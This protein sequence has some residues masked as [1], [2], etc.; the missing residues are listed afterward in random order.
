MSDG[1]DNATNLASG[2]TPTLPTH[3][4]M[5]NNVAE[6]RLE[7]ARR[8][9][10]LAST[11][12]G[13]G[14]INHDALF[15]LGPKGRAHFF[16]LLKRGM[17]EQLESA[18]EMPVQVSPPDAPVVGGSVLD[19]AKGWT[20]QQVERHSYSARAFRLGAIWAAAVSVLT[21]LS[22]SFGADRLA[23]SAVQQFLERI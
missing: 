21:G 15:G 6:E 4:D 1:I 11:C 22:L 18:K 3:A 12:L 10:Q 19:I 20:A 16:D 2:Q 8:A 9:R 7:I 5:A 13:G 23:A 14:S 17:A